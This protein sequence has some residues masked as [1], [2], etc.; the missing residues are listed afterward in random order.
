MI[1]Q[2]SVTQASGEAVVGDADRL[3]L[4]LS[5]VELELVVLEGS[6]LLLELDL[7]VVER[8]CELGSDPAGPAKPEH[9]GPGEQDGRHDEDEL[10]TEVEHLLLEVSLGLVVVSDHVVDDHSVGWR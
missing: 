4:L 10:P 6:L 8:Q 3:D 5:R 1:K 2:N 7:D 9:E